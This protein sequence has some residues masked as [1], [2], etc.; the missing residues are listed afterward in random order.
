MQVSEVAGVLCRPGYSRV[1]FEGP[2]PNPL[3]GG[4]G[5]ASP[6][7]PAPGEGTASPLL[8]ASG[9]GSALPLLLPPGE[10][11]GEGSHQPARSQTS[12]APCVVP[13]ADHARVKVECG[14]DRR[15]KPRRSICRSP[16]RNGFPFRPRCVGG[17][18][19]KAGLA[20]M[21]LICLVTNGVRADDWPEWRGPNRDGVSTET[22]W[23]D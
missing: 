9:E 1:E 4:E 20:A 10:G 6:L 12:G 15:V 21:V 19:F 23:L 5:T 8:P 3:P 17:V 22:N 2:H 16:E 14:V 11:R 18:K 13:P 7:L